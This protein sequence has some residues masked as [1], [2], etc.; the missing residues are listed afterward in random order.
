MAKFNLIVRTG[1]HVLFK[2]GKTVKEDK[3]N[4]DPSFLYF[5][6][7]DIV[8]VGKENGLPGCLSDIHWNGQ[9]I[10]FWNFKEKIGDCQGCVRYVL[11]VV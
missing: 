5:T 10:G 9:R 2:V 8:E 4:G 7:E 6:P 11:L 1:R 3:G